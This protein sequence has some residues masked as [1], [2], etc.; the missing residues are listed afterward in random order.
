MTN[1]DVKDGWKDIC[2]TKGSTVGDVL[3]NIIES[4]SLDD[5]VAD[6]L[7]ISYDT[8]QA[9]GK[10]TKKIK[11]LCQQNKNEKLIE[12]RMVYNE[13]G[14]LRPLTLSDVTLSVR[15][16]RGATVEV[17]STCDSEF[18]M[19]II[20][21]IGTNIRSKF[22]WV[23]N[24]TQQI[25][26]FMDNAGG[27][28]TIEAKNDYV[29]ILLDEFNVKVE[30]QIPNSLETNLLDLGVWMTIQSLV[31]WLHRH[32]MMNVD[33]LASTV[34]EAWNSFDAKKIAKVAERWV[35]VLRLIVKG[36]G[37]NDLVEQ[38]RGL[39]STLF[40]PEKHERLPLDNDDDDHHDSCL[41]GPLVLDD[42]CLLFEEDDD[43]DDSPTDFIAI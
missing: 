16:K 13:K 31:E 15:I 35:K 34:L 36:N 41:G 28:G 6:N 42:R 26:L 30:W 33:T 22:H 29:S 4:Y 5:D 9:T 40:V 8:Y 7:V 37:T 23:P 11:R 25:T 10:K 38:E 43:D 14:I 2:Y 21:N 18:M 39:T 3:F 1:N 24:D 32:K 19:K 20:R 17:D 27:H 12:G